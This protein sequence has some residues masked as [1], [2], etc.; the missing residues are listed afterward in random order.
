VTGGR[1]SLPV[2]AFNESSIAPGN[3]WNQSVVIIG[4]VVTGYIIRGRDGPYERRHEK[5]GR[6]RRFLENTSCASASRAAWAV[7]S[8]Q[9]RNRIWH[10]FVRPSSRQ[11]FVDWEQAAQHTVMHCGRVLRF[12]ARYTVAVVKPAMAGLRSVSCPKLR[13]SSIDRPQDSRNAATYLLEIFRRVTHEQA[14]ATAT[15][16]GYFQRRTSTV[17]SQ[18]HLSANW[19]GLRFWQSPCSRC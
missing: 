13:C 14:F 3:Y 10:M 6:T 16:N 15:E 7:N 2:C 8:W 9:E 1:T 17:S 11:L 12:T 5:T 4:V 18:G 19:H